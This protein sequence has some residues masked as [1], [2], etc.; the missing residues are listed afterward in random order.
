M[1][2][3]VLEALSPAKKRMSFKVG[4]DPSLLVPSDPFL[5]LPAF[6]HAPRSSHGVPFGRFLTGW[7]HRLDGHE[8]G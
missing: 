6:L 2:K 5:T 1:A 7:H 4:E 3:V 8:F